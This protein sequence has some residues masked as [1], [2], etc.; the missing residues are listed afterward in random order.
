MWN[1]SRTESDDPVRVRYP[2]PGQR[3]VDARELLGSPKARKQI[4]RMAE[5]VRAK[6]AHQ[7]ET[8]DTQWTSRSA[9]FR[10][11]GDTGS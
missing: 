4:E 1:R 9:Y 7:R 6:A 8:P 5:L 10:L 3:F 11:F 2:H